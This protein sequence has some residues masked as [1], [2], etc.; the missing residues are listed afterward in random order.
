MDSSFD[1]SYVSRCINFTFIL[2]QFYWENILMII[3]FLSDAGGIEFSEKSVSLPE[4]HYCRANI[5]PLH[6]GIYVDFSIRECLF[7]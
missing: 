7:C 4:L 6:D 5:V 3:F 2:L 1:D